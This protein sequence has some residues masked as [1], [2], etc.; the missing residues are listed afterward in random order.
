MAEVIFNLEGNLTIIQCD[1]ND[2]MKDIINK[3][4]IKINKQEDNLYYLYNGN[5]IKYDLSFKEQAN[6]SDKIRKKMNILVINN[7]VNNNFIKQ[8]ISKEI[9]CPECKENILIYIKN[10]RINLKGCKNNHIQNN[11]LLYL[12]NETQKID[13]SNI[14]RDICK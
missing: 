2:K 14:I 12:F 4:L 10:F 7:N 11:I 3:F 6:E 9:I 13:S 8:K 1:I 5:T